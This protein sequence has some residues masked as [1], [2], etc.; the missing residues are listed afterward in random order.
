MQISVHYRKEDQ[1]LIDQVE[2]KARRERR[3]KSSVII[4]I[5]ESYFESEKRIG[6]ILRDLNVLDTRQLEEGLR[7]QKAEDFEEPL[8]RILIDKGY[9]QHL[10]LEKAL[11]IQGSKGS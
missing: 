9:I 1:Y 2:K 11:S 7:T 3:S 5:I 4:S 6:Q 8:G 10:D